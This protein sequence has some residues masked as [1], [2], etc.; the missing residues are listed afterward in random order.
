[1]E[2]P[3]NISAWWILSDDV[4]LAIALSSNMTDFRLYNA[5]DGDRGHADF[6]ANNKHS[7]TPQVARGVYGQRGMA[8]SVLDWTVLHQSRVALVTE[9]TR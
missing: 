2:E 1:L 7:A 4:D 5:Y 6:V 9:G 8:P 3:K